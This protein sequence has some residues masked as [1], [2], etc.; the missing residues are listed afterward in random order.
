[1]RLGYDTTDGY[2]L[3]ASEAAGTGSQH[4]LG[5]LLQGVKR[6]VIDS[7]FNFKPWSDNLRDLG[8]PTLRPKHVYAGTYL[9]TTTG[10][11]VSDVTNDGST[12]T[13]LNKL[14]KMTGAPS[15]AV[16]TATTDTSGVIGV[17]VDGAGTTGNAQVA[18][19]GLA[20]CVFDGATT[21][22]DYVQI[23]STTAGACHDSGAG[24][25]VSGQVVGRV[26]STNG[27]AGT[28]SVVMSG[29]DVIAP[30]TASVTL[31]SGTYLVGNGTSAVN[32]SGHLFDNGSNAI[33]VRNGSNI[34]TVYT[35]GTF[36]DS[37]NYE[38]LAQGYVSGDGY[39][40]VLPQKAGTGV[41]RGIALGG[42][43]TAGWAIDTTNVLKP[44]S[45]NSKD[46]GT[47][48]LRP[49]DV[50]VGRNLIMSST[51]STYNGKA[52]AGTGIAP[53]YGAVSS[54]AQT[55]AISTTNLCATSSCGAGQ[56][57]VNYY[58]D[59]AVSCA[60]AGSAALTLT[61]G[62][63]DEIGAKTLQVPLNGTGVSGGNTLALGSTSNFGSGD[64]SLWSAGSAAI[65]YSTAY[66]ACTSG[67]GTYA[68]RMTARQVQ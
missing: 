37:S 54:T 35:Y 20:S 7:S 52:T 60:T 33:D 12:G 57:V 39:F 48:S 26:L 9:D 29:P 17:V 62:W 64:I 47:A 22:G 59:S 56:Y 19:G 49:R 34:Q 58:V 24:Y 18:R 5:F 63:T 68:V 28:Y 11:T 13:V 40:E 3:L 32:V 25:P 8:S 10:S 41:Q 4:G 31:T 38:R 55:A 15:A 53:I 2:F 45:D 16:A 65:S 14:A 67:T 50:Y 44:F 1:M 66:V 51:V 36:T 27:S 42:T 21:A 61:I 6:W 23:S 46:F 43:G 30:A